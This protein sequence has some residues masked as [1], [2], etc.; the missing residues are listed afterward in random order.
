M[1]IVE[2]ENKPVA[3][4]CDML[5]RSESDEDE[6]AIEQEQ[7]ACDEICTETCDTVCGWNCNAEYEEECDDE[8]TNQCTED[9]NDQCATEAEEKFQCPAPGVYSFETSFELSEELVNDENNFFATFSSPK[10]LLRVSM[11]PIWSSAS[12]ASAVYCHVP[13]RLVDGDNFDMDSYMSS[14]RFYR[15]SKYSSASIVGVVAL[16][17]LSVAWNRKRTRPT[18]NL[19]EGVFA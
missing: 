15:S 11:E 13:F 6:A 9:C 10:F 17:G 12:E 3:G 4:L 5:E 2:N 7:E 18:I 14:N 19:N 8:C 16:L 1:D